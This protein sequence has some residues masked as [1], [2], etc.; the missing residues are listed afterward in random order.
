MH[1]CI[2]KCYFIT[3]SS[4]GKHTDNSNSQSNVCLSSTASLLGEELGWAAHKDVWGISS[5]EANLWKG[6][7]GHWALACRK[8]KWLLSSPL[9]SPC[10]NEKQLGKNHQWDCILN[11]E[12][13]EPEWLGG[14]LSLMLSRRA[15]ALTEFWVYVAETESSCKGK[16]FSICVTEFKAAGERDLIIASSTISCPQQVLPTLMTLAAATSSL[17]TNRRGS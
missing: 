9:K 3:F 4:P 8:K 7:S 16:T 5:Q 15:F 13:K 11:V 14:L 1:V 10:A 6:L 17:P 12:P 2:T